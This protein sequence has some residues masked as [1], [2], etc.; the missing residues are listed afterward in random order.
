MR[1]GGVEEAIV[2]ALEGKAIQPQAVVTITKNSSNTATVGG[3]V[4]SGT[5]PLNPKGDRILDVIASA[6]GI[7]LTRP[8][9]G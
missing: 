9:C 7:R 4:A 8:L 2:K 3:E 5:V 1:P 6:G